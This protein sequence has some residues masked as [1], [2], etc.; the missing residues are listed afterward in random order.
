MIDLN[1]ACWKNVLVRL[2][3]TIMLASFVLNQLLRG[4]DNF[5]A[6][7]SAKFLH[8]NRHVVFDGLLTDL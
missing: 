7:T 8:Q 3:A 2:S 5:Q 6:A 1:V 4:N